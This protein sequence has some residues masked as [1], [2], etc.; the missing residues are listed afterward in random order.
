VRS[1]GEMASASDNEASDARH[2]VTRRSWV[3]PDAG[4]F[5]MAYSYMANDA[6]ATVTYPGGNAGGLGE[7]VTYGYVSSTG[8]VESVSGTDNYVIDTDYHAAGMVTDMTHL[9]S[10]VANQML[11]RN[12]YSPSTLNLSWTEAKLTSSGTWNISQHGYTYDAWDRVAS[13]MDRYNAYQYQ[14]YTYD[15]YNRLKTAFTTGDV[16]CGAYNSAVGADPFN[17]TYAYNTIGNL[18]SMTGVGSYT[19]DPAH[20][21][22]ANAAG[23]HTF[24]YDFAGN[25]T[26]R[27]IAGQATQNLV[28]DESSRLETIT[29]GTTTTGFLYDADGNRVAR[30][31]NGVTTVMIDNTFEWSSAGG[32][33]SYYSHAGQVIAMRNTAG[34]QWMF[35]D[36]LGSASTVRTPAGV[37]IRQR[38]LPFGRL[39][40]AATLPTEYGFTGQR[41]DP[42][43]LMDYN[44]RQYDPVLGRFTSP[45]TIIP[46]AADPQAFNRYSYVNNNPVNFTDPTGHCASATTPSSGQARGWSVGG[47]PSSLALETSPADSQGPL[48]RAIGAT[49]GDPV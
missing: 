2:R 38:Y 42:S 9:S 28:W 20:K 43:G 46:D 22:Q 35:G 13:A 34:L 7:V 33:V 18:T 36:H 12:I 37:N 19:Y 44:A 31:D 10:G 39:R 23:S 24:S 25:M 27:T 5:D 16:A 6:V 30:R 15:R 11:R 49:E 41:L 1:P 4:T 48:S 17:H 40:G 32:L 21:H 29:Q 26:S 8:E 3:V 45:D 14:C 47:C